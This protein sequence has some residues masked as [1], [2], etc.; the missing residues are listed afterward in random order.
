MFVLP[1]NIIAECILNDFIFY[2][3]YISRFLGSIGDFFLFRAESSLLE[4][5][6]PSSVGQ[7]F[8]KVLT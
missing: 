7:I 8:A 4:T 2:V 6:I 3:F 1:P 5:S